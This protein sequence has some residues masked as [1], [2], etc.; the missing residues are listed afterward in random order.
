MNNKD[1]KT[2]E[3]KLWDVA[4]EL[5]ANSKLTSAQYC[6]PVMGLI[7]NTSIRGMEA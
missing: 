4:D 3:A 5:R 7:S 6:M 2:L 1:L